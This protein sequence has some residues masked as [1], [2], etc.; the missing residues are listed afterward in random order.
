MNRLARA[1]LVVALSSLAA[2]AP[3]ARAGEGADTLQM[4]HPP[5][6]YEIVVSAERRPKNPVEVPNAT[7]IVSGRDLRSRGVR[8]LA[9]ALEDVAGLDTGEGS[10]S[11]AT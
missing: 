10:D 3:P 4:E 1:C 9:E 6:K 7:T 5:G 2:P 8:T 11:A